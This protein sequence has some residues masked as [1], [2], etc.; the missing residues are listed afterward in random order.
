MAY[1]SV[2]KNLMFM[3]I[4]V[5]SNFDTFTNIIAMIKSKKKL[6]HNRGMVLGLLNEFA[7]LSGFVFT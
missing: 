6:P 4:I 1:V 3:Y 5:G 2:H 7:G